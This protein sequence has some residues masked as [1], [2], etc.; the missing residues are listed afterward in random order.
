M[1]DIRH[2]LDSLLWEAAHDDLGIYPVAT[3]REGITTPRTEWQDGWNAAVMAATEKHSLLTR[4][5]KTLTEEQVTQLTELLDYDG[6]PVSLQVREDIVGLHI[7]CG[8]TFAYACADA[9]DFTLDDLPEIYALWQKH[10]YLGLVAWIARKRG[11]EPVKE[12]RY[13]THYLAAKADLTV[14]T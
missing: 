3:I 1:W 5:A 8:D 12:V 4:W 11:H 10:K 13:D 2:T 9:E 14:T 6:E 7:H